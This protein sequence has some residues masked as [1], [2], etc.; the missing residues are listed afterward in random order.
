MLKIALTIERN[1]FKPTMKSNSTTQELEIILDKQRH[2][3][4]NTYYGKKFTKINIKNNLSKFINIILRIQSQHNYKTWVETINYN[5]AQL[6][7]LI[8]YTRSKSPV[9]SL[10]D[11]YTS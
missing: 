2:V 9:C 5:K 11:A 8:M 6:T 4:N 3:S 10:D 7:C 1:S